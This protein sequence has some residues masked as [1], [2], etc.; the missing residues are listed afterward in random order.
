MSTLWKGEEPMPSY[1]GSRELNEDEIQEIEDKKRIEYIKDLYNFTTFYIIS[2][3]KLKVLTRKEKMIAIEEHDI[4]RDDLVFADLLNVTKE[5]FMSAPSK[6]KLKIFIFIP[7]AYA[8]IRLTNYN[9]IKF[10]NENLELYI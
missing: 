4:L 10:R 9:V 5:E 1:S 7:L 2:Y 3:K 8:V 6:E